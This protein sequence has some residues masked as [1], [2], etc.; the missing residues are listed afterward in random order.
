LSSALEQSDLY[1]NVSAIQC[2]E[3]AI[4]VAKEELLKTGHKGEPEVLYVW[5]FGPKDTSIKK[6]G[7][8][9][10]FKSNLP[11]GFEP[12]VRVKLYPSLGQVHIPELL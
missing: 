3:D 10:L 2:E 1:M 6:E 7:W 11:N 12:E 4:L 8:M 5:K 9:V